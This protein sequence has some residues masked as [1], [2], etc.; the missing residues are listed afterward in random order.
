[1]WKNL[2]DKIKSAPRFYLLILLSAICFL[3][4]IARHIFT[5]R[6]VYYFLYWNLFLAAVPWFISLA[7]SSK[8]VIA[9]P[10]LLTV[11]L[12]IVWLLFFPNAPYIITDLY[13]L[14]NHTE[15]MFWYDLIMILLFAWTGLLFG[16]FS[17]DRIKKIWEG[18]LS[19]VKS[20]VLIC[21]LLFLCAFGIYLGRYLRWNSWEIFTEPKQFFLDVLDRLIKPT[22]HRRTWGFTLSMGGFLNI[23]YWSF[24][25]SRKDD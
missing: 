13:Y 8:F 22:D 6:P 23:L 20:I 10:K 16:F 18:K 5:G 24:K 25:I 21:I 1:M 4:I 14:K 15:R 12:F 19:R 17:L 2:S 3:S 11:A 7:V 9:K